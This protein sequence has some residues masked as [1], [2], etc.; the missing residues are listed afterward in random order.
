MSHKCGSVVVLGGLIIS[1]A[2]YGQKRAD[3]SRF[4]VTGDSLGAGYQ[5]S[6]LIESGQVH[7]YANVIAT[8][9][10][11]SLNLPLL[12]SPGYPQILIEPN[13]Y[14]VVIGLTPVA[15]LNT[16]QTL[17]VAV[18]GFTVAALVGL[19]SSCPPDPTNPIY[20]MAAEI[21]NPNC[22]ASP[23]PTELQEA[24]ALKPTTAILW[25]GSNDVLFSLLFNNTDPTD[26]STFSGYYHFAAT[27]MAG[28]SEHLIIANIPDVTL[29]AYLTSVPNLAAILNLSVDEVG[30]L[31]LTPGDMV[32][33][34]AFPFIQAMQAA[35][36]FAPLPDSVSQGPIVIRAARLSQ[37]RADV[38]GYNAAIAYEAA[39]NGATL[40]DIYSLVNDLAAHGAVVGGQKL[41][42]GF[43]GGLFSLDG[44]H[45]TNTGY[46]II[47]NEFIKTMNRSLQ[48]GIP[49]VSVE[50][51]SKTDPLIF[52]ESDRGKHTG[53]VSVGMADGLRVLGRR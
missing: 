53:H 25:V 50:Q 2:L 43:M 18:P 11:V 30:K 22:S 15:R 24:A 6:Q 48:A 33:P 7:G 36:S 39:A 37:I 49:P 32:T 16:Q 41:T 1:A 8:Q 14:A 44:V 35:R 3:F 42:T 46:A 23:G 21:L 40:V 31:G 51:V 52:P 13:S 38:I 19:P 26:V 45:P 12:P 27:T 4:V 34:Y 10:G 20:V 17:D 29:T 47:A 5:N 9:A 28:A